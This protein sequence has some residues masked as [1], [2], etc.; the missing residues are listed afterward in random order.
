M[1]YKSVYRRRHRTAM[2]GWQ[3]IPHTSQIHIT[4]GHIS[5]QILF[6][7]QL[8][9]KIQ[10]HTNQEKTEGHTWRV[11][12]IVGKLFRPLPAQNPVTVASRR[13]YYLFC[14]SGQ[15]RQTQ[16]KQKWMTRHMTKKNISLYYSVSGWGET[17]PRNPLV[18]AR[19][20]CYS[21]KL[22]QGIIFVVT[23]IGI[24]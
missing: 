14:T 8:Q 16:T 12:F 4:G 24:P 13:P 22:S 1:L 7:V 10:P 23:S 9:M 11:P 5:Q 20:S 2:S 15:T 3:P 18:Q 19:C 17:R 6:F 21:I